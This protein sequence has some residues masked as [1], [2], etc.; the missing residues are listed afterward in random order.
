MYDDAS[1]I[2]LA[3]YMKWVPI[4]KLSLDGGLTLMK[5]NLENL[6]FAYN[7]PKLQATFGAQ[8]KMF[9][10]KFRLG[11]NGIYTSN[12]VTNSYR[13]DQDPNNPNALI[14]DAYDNELLSN[15][16]DLN[17]SG[18]YQILEKFSIF[19]LGNNL[20]NQKYERF[21]GYKVLGAQF[22]GG[23]KFRF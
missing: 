21:K 23:V 8:Y 3:G 15:Y 14:F 13:Y 10:N 4:E 18:E 20:L 6:P 11:M 16:L 2:E 5:Y 9:N 12:R 19:A 22:V 17:V 1:K 7:I